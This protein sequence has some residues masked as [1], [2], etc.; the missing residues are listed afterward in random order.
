[1][2]LEDFKDIIDRIYDSA[3]FGQ[4]NNAIIFILNYCKHVVYLKQL[5]NSPQ[6]QDSWLFIRN[7]H[8][9]SGS[10]PCAKHKGP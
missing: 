7:Q 9:L 3:A 8:N 2:L 1:M 4:S 6:N 5:I 10:Q